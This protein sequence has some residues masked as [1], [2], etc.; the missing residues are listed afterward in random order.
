MPAI[1]LDDGFQTLSLYDV[2]GQQH[3]ES[4]MHFVVHVGLHDADN[5]SVKSGDEVSTVHVPY[6][7]YEEGYF[8]A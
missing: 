6:C 7:L 3:P 5:Q 2:I 1:N 4:Q 8:Y